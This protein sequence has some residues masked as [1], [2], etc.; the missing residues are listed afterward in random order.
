MFPIEFFIDFDPLLDTIEGLGDNFRRFPAAFI[1]QLQGAGQE[2]TELY[3]KQCK[4]AM[5]GQCVG[6]FLDIPGSVFEVGGTKCGLKQ[7][8][9]AF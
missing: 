8:L 5:F 4:V 7:V 3:A 6:L 2:L 9:D 1:A